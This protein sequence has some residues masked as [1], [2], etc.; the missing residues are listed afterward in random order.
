MLKARVLAF[1]Y[2]CAINMPSSSRAMMTRM[3]DSCGEARVFGPFCALVPAKSEVR[4]RFAPLPRLI[5][6]C[7]PTHARHGQPRS[8]L[9]ARFDKPE[10]PVVRL[11]G[12]ISITTLYDHGQI[13]IKTAG[14]ETR[15]PFRADRAT[16]GHEAPKAWLGTPNRQGG[17]RTAAPLARPDGCPHTPGSGPGWSPKPG[18]LMWPI[19]SCR[20]S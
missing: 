6:T 5:Q 10:Q 9:A 13:L 12:R 1:S 3:Q 11:P 17:A 4:L 18:P 8:S 16:R 19:P 20:T 15:L 2:S 7:G 14:P